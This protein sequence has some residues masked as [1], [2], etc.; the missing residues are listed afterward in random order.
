MK[1]IDNMKVFFAGFKICL[2][3]IK[4]SSSNYVFRTVNN[5]LKTKANVGTSDPDTLNMENWYKK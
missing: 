4:G 5:Y 3:T 1:H 2:I